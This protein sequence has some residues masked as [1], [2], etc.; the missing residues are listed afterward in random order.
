MSDLTSFAGKSRPE[1][2]IYIKKTRLSITF[3]D[4]LKLKRDF[5]AI[6]FSDSTLNLYPGNKFCSL[7]P[8]IQAQIEK[9]KS[10]WEQDDSKPFNCRVISLKEFFTG[11]ILLK[12]DD[13]SK[14]VERAISECNSIQLD[15]KNSPKSLLLPFMGVADIDNIAKAMVESAFKRIE[16]L[17][18]PSIKEVT[19]VSND[20]MQYFALQKYFRERVQ[21]C[22]DKNLVFVD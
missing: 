10:L 21:D 12:L 6:P 1:E 15:D 14:C 16:S 7:E 9:K 18:C 8:Q 19:M 4:V 5:V 17:K 2:S 22:L 11:Y 20:K 13:P 3:S